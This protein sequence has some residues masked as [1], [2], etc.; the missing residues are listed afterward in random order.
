MRKSFINPGTHNTGRSQMCDHLRE[1]WSKQ[2]DYDGAQRGGES[3]WDPRVCCVVGT[4]GGWTGERGLQDRIMSCL[5]DK[6]R[7]LDFIPDLMG[8][9]GGGGRL[10]E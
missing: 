10:G 5:E 4:S 8:S 2:R 7:I 3:V 9:Y 1:E 6:V